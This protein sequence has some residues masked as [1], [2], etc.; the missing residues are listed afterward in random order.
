[1]KRHLLLFLIS[2]GITAPLPVL[3]GS[4][5]W[6][7]VHSYTYT[8]GKKIIWYVDMKSLYTIRGVTYFNW[9]V[10]H[11]QDGKHQ[12]GPDTTGAA[13]EN[14][15]PPKAICSENRITT[16]GDPSKPEDL[17]KR[18]ANGEW[19][20]EW[21]IARG[22]RPMFDSIVEVSGYPSKRAA[23]EHSDMML[24]AIFDKVCGK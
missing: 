22:F 5:I 14:I 7:P 15:R 2:L 21:Q 8:N 6:E 19:W 20:D 16:G 18:L 17:A 11:W 3:A 24:Q 4:P 10:A 23:L 1:M 9:N 12:F 13:G